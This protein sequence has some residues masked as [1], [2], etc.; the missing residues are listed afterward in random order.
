MA[1]PPLRRAWSSERVSNSSRIGWAIQLRTPRVR[2]RRV[3][4]VESI[5][6]SV[7]SASKV[8]EFLKF[9]S[10]NFGGYGHCDFSASATGAGRAAGWRWLE[11]RQDAGLTAEHA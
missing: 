9:E 11:W 7:L 3:R 4:K 1:A 10:D 6:L 2:I 8:S 5:C